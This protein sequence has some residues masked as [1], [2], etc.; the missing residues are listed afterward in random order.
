MGIQNANWPF[1]AMESGNA[2]IPN[3][4]VAPSGTSSATFAAIFTSVSL[5]G[6]LPGIPISRLVRG[7]SRSAALAYFSDVAHCP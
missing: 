5:A 1:A 6:L 2:P 7:L 3:C 4:S